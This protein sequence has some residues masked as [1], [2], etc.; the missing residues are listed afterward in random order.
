MAVDT[1]EKGYYGTYH[2]YFSWDSSGDFIK[3][4]HDHEGSRT[5]GFG[6]SVNP[7]LDDVRIMGV[8]LTTICILILYP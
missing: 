7:N 3:E 6:E 2:R 5:L 8:A 1:K 4:Q